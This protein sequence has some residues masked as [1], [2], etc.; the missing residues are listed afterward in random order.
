L[1]GYYYAKETTVIY[2][3]IVGKNGKSTAEPKSRKKSFFLLDNR[4][5]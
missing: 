4:E 5:G 2:T 1:E 3:T